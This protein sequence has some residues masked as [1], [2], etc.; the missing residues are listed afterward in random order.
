MEP[1]FVNAPTAPPRGDE[2]QDTSSLVGKRVG[3]GGIFELQTRAAVGGM[4]EI[5]AAWM[6]DTRN[7]RRVAVGATRAISR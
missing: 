3:P 1:S 6:H 2:G 7:P 5:W 4:G